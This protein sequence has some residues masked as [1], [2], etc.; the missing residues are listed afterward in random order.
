MLKIICSIL[1]INLTNNR[2]PTITISGE[3]MYPTI[4]TNDR[5][6]IK[7]CNKYN[8][9]DILIFEFNNELLAHRLLK[10]NGHFFCK[11]DN[12]FRLEEIDEKDIIGKVI[13]KYE[14][15]K[16]VNICNVDETFL[17][18]SFQIGQD[19]LRYKYDKDKTISS[20]TYKI[21]KDKYLK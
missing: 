13:S 11:G 18:L 8:I 4:Q 14:N 9:G 3:S 20:N 16:E 1:K 15:G 10:K 7:K 2:T 19:F 12:S 5:I 21:Y 6:K 17:K